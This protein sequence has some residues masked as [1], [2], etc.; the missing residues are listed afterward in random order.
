VFAGFGLFI[1]TKTKSI[2]TFQMVSM[3]VTM[4]MTFISGAYIP[5]SLVPDT[6]RVIGYF[7]P[8]TYA[9]ALFRWLALEKTALPVQTLV[10]EELAFPVGSFFVITPAV[11]MIILLVFGVVFLLLSTASFLNTD[12]SRM[13]RNKNDAIEFE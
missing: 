12:F 4:P 13:S 2:Q 10:N 5:F 8:M 1:A 11:S 7:N 6:I 3:A 9:V